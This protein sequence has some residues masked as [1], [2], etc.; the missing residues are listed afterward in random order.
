[1]STTQQ[2]YDVITKNCM[3][4]DTGSNFA[5]NIND[6][7]DRDAQIFIDVP[8]HPTNDRIFCMAVRLG[9]T[10]AVKTMLK[11][12]KNKS[13][14]IDFRMQAQHNEF[15]H[16]WNLLQYVCIAGNADMM[17]ACLDFIVDKKRLHLF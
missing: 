16:K 12:Y 15:R 10:F 3:K 2:L 17:L 11:Y 14:G 9:N 5:K 8:G 1:M 6:L 7:L 13:M 4:I